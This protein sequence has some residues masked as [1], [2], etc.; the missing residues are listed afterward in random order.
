MVW[1]H[2]NLR[3]GFGIAATSFHPYESHPHPVDPLPVLRMDEGFFPGRNQGLGVS[4]RF[5][6]RVE[7][8]SMNCTR[9]KLIAPRKKIAESYVRQVH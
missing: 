9:W 3:G 8:F 2:Q 1:V 6:L 7:S 4:R 5:A